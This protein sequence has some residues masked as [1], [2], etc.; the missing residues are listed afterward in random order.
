MKKVMVL[1]L[2]LVTIF[3]PMIV[4]A[5]PTAEEAGATTLRV[6]WWGNPTRDER[7]LA[8]I[9]M[10]EAKY[11]SVTIEAETVGWPGY[12]DRINTQAAAGNMPDVM[13]HDY[14]YLLQFVDRDLMEDL[15]PYVQQNVIDLRGVDESYLSGGRVGG[16]L[17]GVSLGTN[18]VCL[19]YD[20]AI[21]QAA[22]V[23][24][25]STDWTWSDFEQMAK[26]VYDGTG[27]Q[28]IPF[29]TTDPKVGFEN[30][31]RQTGQPFFSPGGKSLGF[32][33]P[34]LLEEYFNIQLRLLDAGVLLDP[35]IAFV[36]VTPQEGPLA[37]GTSWLE[38]VWSN[39]VVSAVDAAA[40]PLE[41]ALLPAIANAA[42]PGTYLKPSM[43]FAIPASAE[44]KD[45]GARF[46][47]FFLNDSAANGVLLGERGVPIISSV[48]TAVK[49]AVDPVAQNVFDFI[50]LVGD[51]HASPIDPP[52]PVGTGEVLKLFRDT[53]QEVLTGRITAEEGAEK[54]MDGA[55]DILARS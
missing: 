22:G 44:N 9:D 49:E 43:F 5:T 32:T 52:D 50:G 16:K 26:D 39:Q 37:Q 53:T 27:V 11:P 20:P 15:T 35:E 48:R 45:G 31:I 21:L 19:V 46:I 1:V 33:D 10:Y 8:V 36:T 6:G 47:N 38:F 18:A 7:T 41:I 54:F 23:A 25:P 55:N 28:T 51:G 13:Q 42:R 2:F 12:W 40:R 17:F 29:F 3:L 34:S 4:A 24:A 14:A 30:W